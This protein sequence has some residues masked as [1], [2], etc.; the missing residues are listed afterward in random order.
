MNCGADG[1]EASAGV[2]IHT[3]VAQLYANMSSAFLLEEIK[4]Q[5]IVLLGAR[6]IDCG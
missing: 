6:P 5:T 3:K 4:V 1:A 2:Q